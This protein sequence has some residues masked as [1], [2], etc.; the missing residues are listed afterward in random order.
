MGVN[1]VNSK[2][3]MHTLVII[4]KFRTIFKGILEN[5][6]V[7]DNKNNEWLSLIVMGQHFK[8]PEKSAQLR[9]N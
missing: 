6:H 8:K 1:E 7:V 9:N 5:L 3:Y 2:M 4:L